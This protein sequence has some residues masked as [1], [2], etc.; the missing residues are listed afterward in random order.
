MGAQ[1]NVDI[2]WGELPYISV[3]SVSLYLRMSS[4]LLSPQE[5]EEKTVNFQ[6]ANTLEAVLHQ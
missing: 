5:Q 2:K 1:S 4:C 3:D 6:E